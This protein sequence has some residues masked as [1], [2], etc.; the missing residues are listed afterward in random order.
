[1]SAKLLCAVCKDAFANPWD[2][3]VHA[4]A[5]H[6]VNIYELGNEANNNYA[7]ADCVEAIAAANANN[8]NTINSNSKNINVNTITPL[9]TTANNISSTFSSNNNNLNVNNSNI[10]ADLANAALLASPSTQFK[11]ELNNNNNNKNI[12]N[13]NNNII[14]SNNNNNSG[15]SGGSNCD[16][17]SIGNEIQMSPTTETLST[18]TSVAG[19]LESNNNSNNENNNIDMITGNMSAGSNNGFMASNGLG[20]D[21]DHCMEGKFGSCNSP[22]NGSIANKEVSGRNVCVGRNMRVPMHEYLRLLLPF[23]T[24][25]CFHFYVCVCMLC[26]R[27]QLQFSIWVGEWME[28]V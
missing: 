19:N 24:R 13:N 4:Q 17:S 5:A 26:C 16:I 25:E 10:T 8:N 15:N 28:V 2:L 14:G 21:T 12:A 18:P 22:T 1:M 6:M 11:L 20:G 23:N 7:T 3:M 9:S 27:L